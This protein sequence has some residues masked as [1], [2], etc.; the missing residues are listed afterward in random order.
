VN[1]HCFPTQVALPFAGM[2]QGLAQAPQL[3]GSLAVSTQP[4]SQKA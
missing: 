3:E 1:P 2:S 4:P